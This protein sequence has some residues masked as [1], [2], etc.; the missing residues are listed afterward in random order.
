[1]HS[2][3]TLLLPLVQP[4]QILQ[5]HPGRLQQNNSKRGPLLPLEWPFPTL[6]LSLP[7]TVI[8]FLTYESL[9]DKWSQ[10]AATKN[11][12][13]LSADYPGHRPHL[14]RQPSQPAGAHTDQDAKPENEL[15]PSQRDDERS[16]S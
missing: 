10:S 8:Y 13:S 9:R 16:H 4:S 7:T 12:P 11:L 2:V 1:M 5:R 3:V 15:F 14:G 6:V